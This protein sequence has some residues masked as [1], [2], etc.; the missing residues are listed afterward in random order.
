MR[1][2]ENSERSTANDER[3]MK[4]CSVNLTEVEMRCGETGTKMNLQGHTARNLN[5]VASF[6]WPVR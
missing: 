1:G 5:N 2:D 3:M 4:R 6:M